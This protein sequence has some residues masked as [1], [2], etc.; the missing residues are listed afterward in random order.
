MIW[1]VKGCF[2]TFHGHKLFSSSLPSVPLPLRWVI[3]SWTFTTLFKPIWIFLWR[4]WPLPPF[5]LCSFLGASLLHFLWYKLRFFFVFHLFPRAAVPIFF[6]LSFTGKPCCPLSS[7][8][9]PFYPSRVSKALRRL[10]QIPFLPHIHAL[11]YP[12]SRREVRTWTIADLVVSPFFNCISPPL[13]PQTFF[14]PCGIPPL[15]TQSRGFP[16]FTSGSDWP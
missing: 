11:I 8:P 9:P 12:R 3:L 15:M 13:Q 16:Q 10:G 14:L 2:C 7:G 6:V 5:F 1:C 4:I